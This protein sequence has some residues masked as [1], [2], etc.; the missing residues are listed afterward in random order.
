MSLATT[1]NAVA[2]G[3]S[4]RMQRHMNWIV[5]VAATGSFLLSFAFRG[6]FGRQ[7]ILLGLSVLMAL[8]VAAILCISRRRESAVA[9]WSSLAVLVTS[10]WIWLGMLLLWGQSPGPGML[11]TLAVSGL[12]IGFWAYTLSPDRER[13]WSILQNLF[14]ASIVAIDGYALFQ[15]G[16][17]GV[18]R[19]ASLFLD[20][21]NLAALNLLCGIP[22]FAALISL[23]FFEPGIDL[24]RL[25]VVGLGSAVMVGTLILT[26]SRGALVAAVPGLGLLA[27]CTWRSAVAKAGPQKGIQI[28]IALAGLVILA[29]VVIAF[30]PVAERLAELQSD[31]IGALLPRVKI[32]DASLRLLP[33]IPWYGSGLG[34][35]WMLF[36]KVQD[37]DDYSRGFNSHN[38]YL[39]LF[40]EGGIPMVVL[41]AAI[42]VG[43][44]VV[45]VRLWRRYATV[46]PSRGLAAAGWV[47]GL[48]AFW[49]HTAVQS[50]LYM[51][52][53]ALLAGLAVGRLRDLVPP[54][55]GDPKPHI[56]G[57]PGGK[58]LIAAF[59][60]MACLT[61]VAVAQMSLASFFYE[62]GLDAFS[63]NDTR[64]AD[65]AFASAQQIAP[66]FD[67]AAI[68]RADLNLKQLQ[69]MG[70]TVGS[71]RLAV[72]K[73]IESSLELAQR[74]NPLRADTYL[75]RGHLLLN[76]S[77]LPQE[78]RV[79][80]ARTAYAHAVELDPRMVDARLALA[81]VLAST[82]DNVGANT[83]L[84][85]GMPIVYTDRAD[86]LQFYRVT[87]EFRLMKGDIAGGLQLSERA[88][89]MERRLKSK[90]H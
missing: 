52:P 11:S 13:T 75:L 24:S 28:S 10:L 67:T 35:Y 26:G 18:D 64:A 63:R 37:A 48:A 7:S 59:M 1:P 89:E 50:N 47:A 87:A 88:N 39:Q 69:A 30:A 32:W 65:R 70:E 60:V 5:A 2:G 27:A 74:F 71:E 42:V 19:P 51:F 58:L 6:H 77:R 90:G 61:L 84:E 34:A 53:L 82:G 57:R 43:T 23:L 15:Y 40:I 45:A 86:V 20:P 33:G 31:P 81:L 62:S 21:N 3:R 80:P 14:L 66:A 54:M 78:K 16:N 73:T 22:L 44:A 38:D 46:P 9:A 56:E 72:I 41:M 85:Q 8:A 83:V 76:D 25:L 4:I 68:A 79:A 36:P 29:A 49:V 12:P 55:N 17:H